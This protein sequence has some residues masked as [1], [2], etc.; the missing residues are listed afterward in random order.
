MRAEEGYYLM[1]ILSGR[2]VNSHAAVT[3]ILIDPLES[4]NG[5]GRQ[6]ECYKRKS[7]F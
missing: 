5:Y 3:L 6:V 4:K 1:N 2:M 7:L